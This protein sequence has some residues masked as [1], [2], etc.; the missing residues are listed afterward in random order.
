MISH[1]K[2]NTRATSAQPTKR[3]WSAHQKAINNP[4]AKK[5][6]IIWKFRLKKSDNEKIVLR[7][8]RMT[9]AKLAR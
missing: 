4:I 6:L 8:Y 1:R 5:N 3:D 2:E 9:K 7:V